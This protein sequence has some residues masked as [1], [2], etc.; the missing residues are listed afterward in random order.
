M[1]KLFDDDDNFT[2]RY[3]QF[4]REQSV[5]IPANK[6]LNA[7]VNVLVWDHADD[8][9]R[10]AMDVSAKDTAGRWSHSA[11]ACLTPDEAKRLADLLLAAAA[12]GASA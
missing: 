1:A 3:I 6:S 12:E 2:E 7:D 9:G 8:N 5:R 10:I 11:S 4:E